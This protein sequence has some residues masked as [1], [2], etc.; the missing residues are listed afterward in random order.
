MKTKRSYRKYAE[1]LNNLNKCLNK[2]L[3]SGLISRYSGIVEFEGTASTADYPVDYADN[4]YINGDFFISC[5]ENNI[6]FVDYF[7]E[8]YNKLSNKLS[9]ILESGRKENQISDLRYDDEI[10]AITFHIEGIKSMSKNATI[11]SFFDFLKKQN[12]RF[13]F[14]TEKIIDQFFG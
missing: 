8:I 11:K 12:F 3:L 7:A 4:K 6:A 14:G 10:K 13:E 9:S 5:D 1:K 2:A